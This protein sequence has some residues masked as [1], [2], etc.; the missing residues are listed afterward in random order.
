[1]FTLLVSEVLASGYVGSR[2]CLVSH[3]HEA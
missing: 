2:P 3:L 1:M